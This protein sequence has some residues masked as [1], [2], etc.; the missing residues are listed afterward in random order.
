MRVEGS[1][2]LTSSA[3]SLAMMEAVIN[4]KSLIDTWTMDDVAMDVVAR[5]PAIFRGAL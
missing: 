1:A 5:M 4:Q 3:V 2:E